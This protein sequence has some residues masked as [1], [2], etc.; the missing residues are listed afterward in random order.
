MS[1]M[2]TADIAGRKPDEPEAP[3]Q[4][5][6]R[7]D[8]D[9]S[10]AAEGDGR[11]ALLDAA[12]AERFHGRWVE[13]QT[14]F[15]DAPRDAVHEADSLVAELMQRLAE[16]FSREREGLESQWTRG[17]DVSTEDLRVALTRYRS[18]FDRLLET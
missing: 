12:E 7:A 15:V 18:F 16:T 17:E 6:A 13:L 14:R 5:D 11:S 1:D 9:R 2:S 8:A 3:T 4:A 10:M